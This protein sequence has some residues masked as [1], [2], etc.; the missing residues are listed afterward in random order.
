MFSNKEI[1]CNPSTVWDR[2]AAAWPLPDWK[3]LRFLMA[4]PIRWMCRLAQYLVFVRFLFVCFFPWKI[5]GFFLFHFYMPISALT[6]LISDYTRQ[7]VFRKNLFKGVQLY[8]EISLL[9]FTSYP[10]FLSICNSLRSV[11]CGYVLTKMRT[12]N[13][14][15]VMEKQKWLLSKSAWRL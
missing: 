10:K 1:V 3:F 2:H 12:K 7:K 5:Y 15:L 13:R 6:R 14:L 8:F 4:K 11:E 9:S